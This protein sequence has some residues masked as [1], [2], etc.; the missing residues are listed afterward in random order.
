MK[1]I[2]LYIQEVTRRLP[3][4]MRKDIALELRSTIEDMLP[5]DYSEHDVKQQL[6]KLG[7]PISLAAQYKDKPMHLIGPKFYDMYISILKM[8]LLIS[9]VVALAFFLF[10]KV[11]SLTGNETLPLFIITTFGESIWVLLDTAIQ[12]FFWVT[13][14]FIILERTIAPTIHTPLTLSGQQWTPNDLEELS[15]LP[16]HKMIKKSEIVFSFLWTVILALLYFNATRLI[17]VYESMDGQQSLQFKLPVFNGDSLF[18][19]WP[20][21]VCYLLL[22]LL[23]TIYKMKTRIWTYKLAISNVVVHLVGTF[24]LLII[25]NDPHLLNTD[26]VTYMA[27]IFNQSF[28]RSNIFMTRLTWGIVFSIIVISIIDIFTSFLKASSPD[29]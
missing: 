10:E 21:I 14:V 27:D 24:I 28:D 20:L 22:E 23:L 3:D 16:H 17:G 2:D 8:V 18:S 26:F 19:Y 13:L 25:V 12:A 29:E 11:G 4:K 6:E 1:L 7:N 15:Y 9:S 5:D